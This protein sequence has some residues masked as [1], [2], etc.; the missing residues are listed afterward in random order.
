MTGV[1][2][3]AQIFF[4]VSVHT[5]EKDNSAGY[6]CVGITFGKRKHPKIRR[7][8]YVV[9]LAHIFLV[10]CVSLHV[11]FHSTEKGNSAGYDCV[12]IPK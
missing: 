12:G 7:Q 9:P 8:V 11:I 10:V 5:T 2:P 1:V 4:V 3:L 6:G